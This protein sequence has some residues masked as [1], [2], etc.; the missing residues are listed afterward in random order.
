MRRRAAAI[1]PLL[2]LRAAALAA[3]G[4]LDVRLEAISRELLGLPYRLGPLGEEAPPDLDPRFRLDAFDCT[5]YVETVLAL[6]LAG[7]DAA[8]TDEAAAGETVDE[9]A[10]RRWL[11]SIRYSGDVPSFASRR[12]LIDAQ[13]IPGLIASGFV[14]D[15]TREIGGRAARSESIRLR[16]DTWER[17]ALATDLGLPW[18]A[19]PAGLHHLPYLPWRVL[20]RDRVRAA[21][22]TTAVLSLVATPDPDLPTLVTHQ[23]L[24]LRL[25]NGSLVVRHATSRRGRVVEEPLDVFLERSAG[26]RSRS[27]VGV[28]V[29]AIVDPP[30]AP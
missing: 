12:H 14:R 13:W 29:L 6:S 26:R 5:T 16:R 21:L 27:V 7:P 19:L 10:A 17:S 25:E 24:L 30:S 18:S 23:A 20:E 8:A 2:L 4:D 15:V 22:P 3:A 11:D 28:N 1:A 9:A